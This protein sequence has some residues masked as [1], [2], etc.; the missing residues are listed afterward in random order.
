MPT[1]FSSLSLSQPGNF[2]G[3]ALEIIPENKAAQA[4]I[5]AENLKKLGNKHNSDQKKNKAQSKI[6][7]QVSMRS[8]YSSISKASFMKMSGGGLMGSLVGIGSIGQIPLEAHP[9]KVPESQNIVK[10]GSGN[11]MEAQIEESARNL[12]QMNI[13]QGQG[14][15]N[16][17]R[18]AI[19][20]T[21]QNSGIS[22]IPTMMSFG[23]P[24]KNFTPFKRRSAV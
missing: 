9:A 13:S 22:L 23:I 8:S 2:K 21:A 3:K 10:T 7:H 11:K 18:P 19:E 6:S 15:T 5:T 4:M 12:E 1:K 17:D 20:F 14:S 16:S 24:G